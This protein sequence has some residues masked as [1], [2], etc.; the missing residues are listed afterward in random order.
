LEQELCRFKTKA[1]LGQYFK[2]A[3]SKKL[4]PIRPVRDFKLFRMTDDECETHLADADEVG[5]DRK[6]KLRYN[7]EVD[8]EFIIVA[9]N[10]L[11]QEL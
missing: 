11:E 4:V 5:A 1:T 6:F 9:H 7:N 8:P 2:S 3:V 10:D